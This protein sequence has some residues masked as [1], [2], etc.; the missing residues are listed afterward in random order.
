MNASEDDIILD[1][2]EGSATTTSVMD[3][4]IFLGMISSKYPL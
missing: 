2:F 1:F 3:S 4:N